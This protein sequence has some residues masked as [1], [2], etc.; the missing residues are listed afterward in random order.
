MLDRNLKNHLVQIS[1]EAMQAR[2]CIQMISL[3][4]KD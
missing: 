4:Q 1:V 3:F 2:K